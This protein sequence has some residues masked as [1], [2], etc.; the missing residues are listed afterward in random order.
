MWD[1]SPG[2]SVQA[3]YNFDAQLWWRCGVM[4]VEFLVVEDGEHARAS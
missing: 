3:A 4:N 2:R 1:R